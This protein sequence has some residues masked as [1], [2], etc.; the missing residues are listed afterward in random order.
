MKLTL[1]LIALMAVLGFGFAGPV[2]SDRG[3]GAA[4]SPAERKIAAARELIARSPSKSQGYN[5]LAMALA[6]RA[7]ETADPSHYDQADKALAESRKLSPG[8]LEAERIDVWVLLGKHEFARALEKAKT[9]NR[10]VPDDVMTYG[11]LVDAYVELGQYKEAEESAQWMINLRPGSLPALTRTAYLRELFGDVE[12]AL[13]SMTEAL[14][15][16]PSWESEERAW[17][18]THM[19]HLHL[20]AGRLDRAQAPA[21]DALRLFPDY[22]Y[23]LAELAKVHARRGDHA[24]AAGLLAERFRVAPHPENLFDWAEAL[25]R[26]GRTGEARSRFAQFERLARAEMD[27]VDNANRELALYLVDHAKRP[28]EAVKIMEREMA[29][30][31]DVN[32]LDVYAWALFAAGRKDEARRHMAQAI[33]VGTIDPTIRRHATEILGNQP[34]ISRI[35]ASQGSV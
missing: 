17:V 1:S 13:E 6:R 20:L 24:R 27:G 7:R 35:T 25:S 9:L 15:Q 33:E 32:T 30:R 3:E 18:L 31:R 29:W 2:A 22:H 19:A 10:K 28:A 5:D 16:V 8:N 26:A 12:G 21:E 11:M 4:P 34:R 23:A 14:E